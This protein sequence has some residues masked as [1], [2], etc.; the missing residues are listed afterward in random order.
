MMET[1]ILPYLILSVT[2]TIVF[3]DFFVRRVLSNHLVWMANTGYF[4]LPS[5]ATA[6]IDNQELY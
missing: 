3:R 6:H 2:L 1:E 5:S 4:I